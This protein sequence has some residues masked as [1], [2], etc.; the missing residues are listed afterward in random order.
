MIQLYNPNTKGLEPLF[1]NGKKREVSIYVCGITPYDTTHLGHAFTYASADILVR[2]L[3]FIGHSVRYVQNVTDVDDDILRRAGKTGEDWK[4]LGDRWTA[5][6]IEDM[7]AINVRPPDHF[8]RATE[9]IP[10]II[11]TVSAL[12]EKG[13]AYERNGSVYYEV[14]RNPD[15][16]RLSGMDYEDMLATA[17]ERGNYPDDPNKRD[18]L[19][20]VLWQAA[21][22]SRW[23]ENE[24]RWVSPWGQGR[25]GWHIECS[26]MA[27]KFLGETIDIHSGGADL[28]FPHHCC[29]MAQIEPL[30]GQPFVRFWMHAA[31]VRQEGEK[32][33]KSLG[34]L[35]WARELLQHYSADALRL[36]MAGHHYAI[37]WSHDPGMLDWAALVAERIRSAAV[38]QGGPG[39]Q[40]DPAPWELDFHAALSDNLNSPRVVSILDDL[41]V[42]ILLAAQR[43][44]GV[45]AAQEKM[46]AFAGVF[47][48]V[49]D[50][51]GPGEEVAR[52]W[53]RHLEKFT[54]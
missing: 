4:V 36:Y 40:F 6:F 13:V 24:P 53:R 35:V 26:T 5:H 11:T 52:G 41:A 20:F 19:D 33:S 9:V 18:P 47:G 46:R 39:T 8:P 38:V 10:E 23:T 29:E 16:G 45:A 25:P 12:I 28:L 14:R 54:A 51:N 27:T 3:E 44:E 2:Y 49:L 15:F 1:E 37:E 32:M 30:T 31:M 22:P 7:I 42:N 34:N 17:N 43:G 48:L 50:A 21:D